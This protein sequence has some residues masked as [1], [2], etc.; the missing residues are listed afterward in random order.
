MTTRRRTG[1]E[2]RKIDTADDTD[3]EVTTLTKIESDE[4]ADD[5]T[6]VRVAHADVVMSQTM[7]DHTSA[8]GET[9]LGNGIRGDEGTIPRGRTGLGTGTA[10]RNILVVETAIGPQGARK[11]VATILVR[12]ARANDHLDLIAEMGIGI[13][14]ET[15]APTIAAR[16]DGGRGMAART[17]MDRNE[18]ATEHHEHRQQTVTARLSELANLRPCSRPPQTWMM[19]ARSGLRRKMN[20]K[21]KSAKRMIEA[22]RKEAT[23]ALSTLCIKKLE[24]YLWAI[25]WGGKGKTSN[26]TM[27]DRSSSELFERHATY[28]IIGVALSN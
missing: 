18:T 1:H 11:A 21:G 14:T 27:I 23:V 3:I 9:T 8:R 15:R 13:T 7:N 17:V 26:E 2:G 12:I 28:G 22:E 5:H 20:A 6:P 19:I 10:M 25:V 24:I 16:M 4:G